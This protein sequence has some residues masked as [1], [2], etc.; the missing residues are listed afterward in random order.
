MVVKTK[1]T[2]IF[3]AILLSF[4]F[5][6]SVHADNGVYI[7]DHEYIGFFDHDGIYTVIAGIKNQ[8]NFAV[9]PTLTVKVND[10]STMISS[11]YEF[12]TIMPHQML[13]MKIKLPE[14][15]SE[16]PILEAPLITYRESEDKFSGGYVIY[17]E[18]L[19][20]HDDASL[21]GKIRNGGEEIFDNFRIY[22]LI[23]DK[24][25]NILDVAFSDKF[26]IMKPGDVFDFKLMAGSYIVNDVDYYSC[27]A[28]GDDA[29]MP[30]TVKKGDGEMTFRYTANAWFKDGKFNS[31]ETVLTLY[32][33]NGFQMPVIGSF[34]FPTNSI[35]EKYDV[36]LDGEK[37]EDGASSKDPKIR[38]TEK[39]QTLQSID[40]MGNWHLY[41]EVPAGFQG[42]VSISGF[43]KNDGTFVV[44]DEIDL[45]NLVY[46]EITGGQVKQILA[47]PND[48]SLQVLIES[49]SD[50]HLLI[51]MNEFLLKPFENDEYLAV[52]EMK[53]ELST[54]DKVAYII[55]DT[56]SFDKGK[57]ITIPFTAG[58]EKIEIFG[59]YVV[60]EFG[61]I[62]MLILIIGLISMIIFSKK[63]DS[64][65]NLFYRKL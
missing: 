12:S 36:V 1:L 2:V 42:N 8:E 51:K 40:E 18:T 26:D 3:T 25:D 5:S 41:F 49:E 16:N 6:N 15:R 23:K 21:T 65:T 9:V 52:T 11:D 53:P 19:V 48:A 47:I 58:T 32:S 55:T 61:H 30:L 27:F 54:G 17:D 28:F 14:V 43:M 31:D 59:S 57:T 50:G 20:I 46:Y 35:N 38:F 64:I 44:P 24:N 7:P 10:G 4:L 60:P 13:P 33:L 39:I 45:T 29:I 22:A 62:V 63:T 56:F 37:F 34:E